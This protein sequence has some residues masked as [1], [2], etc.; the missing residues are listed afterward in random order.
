MKRLVK[1]DG[2][3]EMRYKSCAKWP[4]GTCPYSN[5]V[6]RVVEYNEDVAK[7][8]CRALEQNGYGGEGKVFPF[9]TWV[10]NESF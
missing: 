4:E 3:S 7:G 2:D 10:E 9:K 6:T 5:D 8:V 1:T